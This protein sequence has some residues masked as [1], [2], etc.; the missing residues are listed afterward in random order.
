MVRPITMKLAFILFTLLLCAGCGSSKSTPAQNAASWAGTW[1]GKVDWNASGN[2]SLGDD[3]R[4]TIATPAYTRTAGSSTVY[5]GNFT[6]TDVGAE[7]GNATLQG[8]VVMS[9][10]F[11]LSGGV[12][13]RFSRTGC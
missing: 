1:S 11:P 8:G 2:S 9:D 12:L 4:I 7:L 13:S 5:T 3:V 6:G 10:T